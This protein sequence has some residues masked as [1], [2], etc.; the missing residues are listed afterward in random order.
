MSLE[1]IAD[2]EPAPRVKIVPLGLG[3]GCREMAATMEI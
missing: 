1:E 2:A 3:E